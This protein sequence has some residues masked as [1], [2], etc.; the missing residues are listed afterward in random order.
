MVAFK[1]RKGYVLKL[2]SYATLP[3]HHLSIV[4]KNIGEN[5][6]FHDVMEIICLFLP[7]ATLL[8]VCSPPYAPHRSLHHSADPMHT[9]PAPYPNWNAHHIYQS[10]TT[11]IHLMP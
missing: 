9:L 3:D 1:R 7:C 8:T 10:I 4:S 2:A 6:R 11:S 5:G